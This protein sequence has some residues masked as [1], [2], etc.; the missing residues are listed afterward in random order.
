[1]NSPPDDKTVIGPLDSE[2]QIKYSIRS[3]PDDTLSLAK[4]LNV[5]GTTLNRLISVFS[6]IDGEIL[7]AE[8]LA[9]HLSMTERNARR[10]LNTLAAHGMA[11]ENGEEY[12]GAG[13]PR[14][15][16]RIDVRKILK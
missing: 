9:R 13:R 2:L 4:Q 7:G 16:Y 1:M 8:T 5:S 6:K 15:M 11:V 10:L 12:R 14:K 3:G